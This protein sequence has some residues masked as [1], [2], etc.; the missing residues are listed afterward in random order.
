MTDYLDTFEKS[1][2]STDLVVIVQ[3]PTQGL[4]YR[5]KQLKKLPASVLSVLD[6]DSRRDI[7]T[8][9]DTLQLVA[10]TD[11]VLTGQATVHVPIRQ[12]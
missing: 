11:W 3:T 1:H 5:G 12:E 2:K 8:A 7:N 9:A 6:D 10:P 4:Q